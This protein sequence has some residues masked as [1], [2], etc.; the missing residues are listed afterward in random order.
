MC[1]DGRADA[2]GPD[3]VT[4]S[5]GVQVIADYD[6]P[7]FYSDGF[8]WR[9]YGG[10]WYRSNYYTGGWVYARPPVAVL[11]IDRPYAYRHYRPPAGSATRG[12]VTR[13]SRVTSR[14]R[15]P[16]VIAAPRQ[17]PTAAPRRPRTARP[18]SAFAAPRR[19]RTGAHRRPRPCDRSGAAP[20]PVP[21][22]GAGAAIDE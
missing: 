20:R 1:R 13:A 2:Y 22:R 16:P 10:A 9:Y 6:E 21:T 3:L 8:Y 14:R 18:A 19:P 11:R 15:R 17:P 7:I 12:P 4:V 5:P